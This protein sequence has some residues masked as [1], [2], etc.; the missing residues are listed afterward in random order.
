MQNWKINRLFILEIEGF[1]AHSNADSL[2]NASGFVVLMRI[3]KNPEYSA[4]K[5]L[6]D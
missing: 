3:L 2:N 5:E 6:H 1:Y 4:D